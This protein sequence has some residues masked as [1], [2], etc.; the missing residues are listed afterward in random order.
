MYSHPLYYPFQRNI[1]TR[2]RRAA[3]LR[4]LAFATLALSGA[5]VAFLLLIVNP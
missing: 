5:G 1:F 4:R 3:F 2:S